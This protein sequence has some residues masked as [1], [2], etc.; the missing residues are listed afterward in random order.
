MNKKIEKGGIAK[1]A[2][3]PEQNSMALNQ[4]EDL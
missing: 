4:I 3:A 2:I 1:D